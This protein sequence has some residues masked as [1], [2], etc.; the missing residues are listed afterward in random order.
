MTQRSAGQPFRV[1]M[2]D[3]ANQ[4]PGYV[5]PLCAALAAQGC[6]IELATAPFVYAPIPPPPVPVHEDFAQCARWPLMRRSQGIRQVVRGLEYPFDWTRVMRRIARMRPHIVHVQWAMVPPVDAVAFGAIRASGARLVYTAHDIRP[7]YGTLRR[8]LLSTR[9][10]YRLADHLIVHTRAAQQQLSRLSGVPSTHISV[11]PQGNAIDRSDSGVPQIA[12]RRWLGVPSAAPVAL[13]FGIVKRYKGLDTLL[14]A[15][16]DVLRVL[17]NARLIIAGRPDGSF[18]PY[19][20]L[21]DELGIGT[22]VISRLS[23]IEQTDVGRYFAAADVVVLPYRESDNSAVL[24]QAYSLG[25]PV[26]VSPVDG[27]AE[28]VDH[29]VSGFVVPAHG[30]EALADALVQVLADRSRA[31][32][33]GAQARTRALEHHDWSTCARLTRDLY[34]RVISSL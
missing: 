1:L 34:A 28:V 14:L 25:R 5:Y 12:A 9:R 32:W 22:Q 4:T 31:A 24:V 11:V 29:G 18:A 8:V 23:Y 6:Q 33:M 21:I 2:V 10:L 19:Q 13:F 26:I 16:R 15:M 30:P 7:R 27:L 17:P 20:Q 3:A